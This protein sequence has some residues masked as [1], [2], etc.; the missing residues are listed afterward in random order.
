MVRLTGS[1]SNA[2]IKKRSAD[3]R[4]PGSGHSRP[5][6]ILYITAVTDQ[7]EQIAI[8]LDP[9]IGPDV[10]ISDRHRA[11][12][13]FTGCAPNDVRVRKNLISLI[14][15]GFRVGLGT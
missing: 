14:H 11:G 12:R 7:Q 3:S 15:P 5:A 8:F 13:V 10:A 6:R 4:L 1:K 9:Y 2:T